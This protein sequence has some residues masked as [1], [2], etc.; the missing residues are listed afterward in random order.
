MMQHYSGK[1]LTSTRHVKVSVFA[2]EMVPLRAVLDLAPVLQ[3]WTPVSSAA[4]G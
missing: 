1:A 2:D 3:G 4:P